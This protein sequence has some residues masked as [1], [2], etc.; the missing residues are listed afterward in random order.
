VGRRGAAGI[1]DEAS[2]ETGGGS[3]S[4]QHVGDRRKMAGSG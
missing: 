1:I 2:L 3:G 4:L